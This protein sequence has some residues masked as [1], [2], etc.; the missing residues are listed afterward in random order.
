MPL[1]RKGS[2]YPTSR[3][4]SRRTPES[5]PSFCV[6]GVGSNLVPTQPNAARR[7]LGC[8]TV[9]ARF[10]CGCVELRR[11]ASARGPITNQLL[12]V[13]LAHRDYSLTHGRPSS[14]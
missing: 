10:L 5:F 11:D 3:L 14:D 7:M 8:V 13:A 1:C 12:C 6:V 9:A 2:R 4:R